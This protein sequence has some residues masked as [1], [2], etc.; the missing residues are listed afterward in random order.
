ME[1]DLRRMYS[2]AQLYWEPVL[3][4]SFSSKLCNFISSR[5]DFGKCFNLMNYYFSLHKV[6]ESVANSK[7]T[8]ND[9]WL[10]NHTQPVMAINLPCHS[11]HVHEVYF[12][13]TFLLNLFQNYTF[14]LHASH[15]LT[16]ILLYLCFYLCF[17]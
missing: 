16:P 14:G 17:I 1:F 12:V 4:W 9:L 6:H 3:F 8:N 10:T 11:W 5:R 15:S 13:T 2:G 7:M